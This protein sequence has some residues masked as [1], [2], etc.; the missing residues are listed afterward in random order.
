MEQPDWKSRWEQGEIGFHQ[1][2]VSYFLD[3]Y[4]EQ[5]W[6]PEGLGRVYV[7]LCGKSIDMVF[8]AEHGAEVV[9]VEYVEQAVS[10]FFAERGLTPEIATSPATRYR[11]GHYTLFAADLFSLTEEHLDPIDA[12]YDRAS[13]VALDRAT[14]S[15]YADHMRS[16]LTPGVKTLLVTFDYDQA[17]MNGP[18]FAV[19]NDEVRLLFGD[20]FEVEHLETRDALDERFRTRG[21]EA[22]LE[23]AFSLTRL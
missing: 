6:G 4:A 7:P 20:G 15:R 5:V 18:P 23:S 8:L 9:G 12:V 10:E 11:A 3:K 13:V 14:R 17:E 19:S 16:V 22:M 1:A 2:D 21:L